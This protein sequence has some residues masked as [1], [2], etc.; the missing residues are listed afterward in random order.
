LKIV[1]FTARKIG[2]DVV[3]KIMEMVFLPLA[4]YGVNSL[5][6]LPSMLA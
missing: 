1:G 5:A 6:P 2:I 4:F 3:G